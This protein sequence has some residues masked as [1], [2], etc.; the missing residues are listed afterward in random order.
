MKNTCHIAF[1]LMTLSLA[2]P[3]L[4]AKRL[5]QH[6]T[7]PIHKQYADYLG[8]PFKHIDFKRLKDNER[9]AF[10]KIYPA[11]TEM[12]ERSGIENCIAGEAPPFTEAL[13]RF[14]LH[15]PKVGRMARVTGAF[16]WQRNEGGKNES[17]V[18]RTTKQRYQVREYFLLHRLE[19]AGFGAKSPATEATLDAVWEFDQLSGLFIAYIQ[20]LHL[21]KPENQ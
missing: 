5:P 16:E 10:F 2:M 1:V 3:A 15:Y 21:T 6:K 11:D 18:F 17:L 19:Q 9:T 7:W 12:Q 4:A 20:R 13:N 14:P 8:H